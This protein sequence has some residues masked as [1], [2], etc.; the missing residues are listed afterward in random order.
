M[1]HILRY[2]DFTNHLYFQP[3]VVIQIIATPWIKLKH[4]KWLSLWF[5]K[6][7]ILAISYGSI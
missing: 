1:M 3:T 2:K 6:C 4:M 5:K 7:L